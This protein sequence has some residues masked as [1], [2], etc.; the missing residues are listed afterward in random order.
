M[1]H[2]IGI[3]PRDLY[4]AILS[5]KR[6]FDRHHRVGFLR[7]GRGRRNRRSARDMRCDVR[8]RRRLRSSTDF[9]VGFE[10][11]VADR[12]APGR[13]DRDRRS[14]SLESLVS[15]EEPNSKNSEVPTMIESSGHGVGDVRFVASRGDA[16]KIA[17]DRR[18]AF[19]V[20][21]LQRPCRTSNS[22]RFRV[23]RRRGRGFAHAAALSRMFWST[24]RFMSWRA[25][26]RPEARMRSLG[27]RFAAIHPP[28]AY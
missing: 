17:L 15:C 22:R 26:K 9:G 21:R 8:R 20:D 1:I 25:S 2:L 11:V 6:R 13:P 4:P 16:I 7:R 10:V 27:S 12:E 19:G 28:Q 24:V 18:E 23:R 5:C 14:P 3:A